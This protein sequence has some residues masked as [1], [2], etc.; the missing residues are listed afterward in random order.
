[1]QIAAAMPFV[2][3]HSWSYTARTWLVDQIIECEFIG[4]SKV[5]FSNSAVKGRLGKP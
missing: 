2:Q 5:L 4:L 1:M 3:R